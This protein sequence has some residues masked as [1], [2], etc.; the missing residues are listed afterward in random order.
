MDCENVKIVIRPAELNDKS[1]IMAT[2]LRG[3]YYGNPFFNFMPPDLY[4]KLYAILITDI[5]FSDETR[6]DIA[7]G[8]NAPEWIVG[9]IVYTGPILHW[10]YVKVDYRNRGIANMLCKEKGITTSSSTTK[11]GQAIIRKKGLIFNPLSK[12][13]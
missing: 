2:W 1:F 11:S 9:F 13:L 7:C 10:A 3:N 5:L 4:Y 8:E 6:I 12:G